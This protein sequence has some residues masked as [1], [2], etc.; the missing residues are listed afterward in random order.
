M[1]FEIG[2]SWADI[3][4]LLQR[5][6]GRHRRSRADRIGCGALAVSIAAMTLYM[7]VGLF[8]SREIEARIFGAGVGIFGLLLSAAIADE[9]LRVYDISPR[10]VDKLVP[11]AGR[12]WH[13]EP[14]EI[15]SISLDFTKVWILRIN[16]TSDRTRTV[17][18]FGTLRSALA[19]LYPEIGS[20]E[21]L[22]LPVKVG[23]FFY[24]LLAAVVLGTGIL[25]WVLAAKG[26]LYW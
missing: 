3:Q 14:A 18:L 13:I 19:E 10:G 15:F 11:L 23:Y 22:R 5:L 9:A 17:P 7:A 20:G 6:S 12:V 2:K 16:L 26:L 4:V 25:L 8:L 21:W 1:A 24:G